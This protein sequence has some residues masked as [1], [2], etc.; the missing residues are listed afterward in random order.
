M[1]R[2][3]V[4]KMIA[5]KSVSL[6]FGLWHC[7]VQSL[8]DDMCDIFLKKGIVSQESNVAKYGFERQSPQHKALF[9]TTEIL[10]VMDICNLDTIRLYRVA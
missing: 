7:L 8:A 2:S 5:R 6:V 10:C 9:D 1:S 4:G 3:V